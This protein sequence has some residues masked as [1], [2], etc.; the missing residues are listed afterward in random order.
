MHNSP[1]G[2]LS[3]PGYTPSGFMIRPNGGFLVSSNHPFSFGDAAREP[4]ADCWQALRRGWTDERVRRWVKAV[5]DNSKL[6][7]MDLVP[8]LDEEV[9]IVSSAGVETKT[10]A[11]ANGAARD[12]GTIERALEVLQAKSPSPPEDGIGDLD[13][14]RAKVRELALARRY[15]RAPTDCAVELDGEHTV[16]RRARTVRLN[17]TASSILSA[18]ESGTAADAVDA[19]AERYSDVPRSELE[20]AV[21]G[22]VRKLLDASVLAPALARDPAA[23]PTDDELAPALPLGG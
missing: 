11:P 4:L 15:K 13:A 6:P 21:L 5:P 20:P 18:C 8:Y 23:A 7:E 2:R 19:L 17:R 9:Q 16:R 14:A 1:S 12:N 22:T 10:G 3:R